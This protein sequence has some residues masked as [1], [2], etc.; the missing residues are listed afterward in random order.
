MFLLTKEGIRKII[1]SSLIKY[2]QFESNDVLSI[3]FDS[4]F[5]EHCLCLLK[6]SNSTVYYDIVTKV[7]NHKN[8]KNS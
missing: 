7:I 2:Y 4:V 5:I 6:K 1:V 3:Y 8:Y